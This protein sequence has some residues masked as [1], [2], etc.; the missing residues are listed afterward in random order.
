M[1][2]LAFRVTEFR[3]VDDTGW[4]ETDDVTALIGTNE[5]GKTNVLVPLWKL[6]P[7]KNGAIEPLADF[8]RKRYN[9]IRAMKKK[10]TFIRA[11]FKLTSAIAA[12]VAK[13][14]K[15]TTDKADEVTISRDFGGQHYVQFEKA[16]IEPSVETATVKNEVES[17][18]KDITAAKPVEGDAAGFHVGRRDKKETARSD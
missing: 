13:L 11:R 10:P 4:I 9:E 17:A 6:K 3:S 7:A 2:L 12:E 1:K 16:G 15:V 8:P 18:I 14:L 5:A